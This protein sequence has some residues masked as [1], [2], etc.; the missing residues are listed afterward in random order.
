MIERQ[1]LFNTTFDPVGL[2]RLG[3]A[4]LLEVSMDGK[5]FDAVS[6]LLVRGL[7]RRKAFKSLG[8]EERPPA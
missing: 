8:P 7:T 5:R 4:A 1:R 6:K 2:D 3:R